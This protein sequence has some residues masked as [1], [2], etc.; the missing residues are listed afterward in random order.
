MRIRS[1]AGARERIL[2]AAYDLFSR[3]GDRRGRD[4]HDPG[5][6]RHRQDE[7]IPPLRLE[8]PS[9]CVAFLAQREQRVDPRLARGEIKARA[10]EP[11]QR[12]LAIFDVFDGWFQ[13]P[14]FEGC[15]FINVLLESPDAG[16]VRMPAA[17][18]L[19]SIRTI[20]AGLAAEAGLAD[21][22]RFA[23]T[24]HFLMK[25]SIV[26]ARRRACDD[27]GAG[28]TAGG[29]DHHRALATAMS[30]AVGKDQIGGAQLVQ[31]GLLSPRSHA[32]WLRSRDRFEPA[33]GR[34]GSASSLAGTGASAT[35][36]VLSAFRSPGRHLHRRLQRH[37]C[38]LNMAGSPTRRATTDCVTDWTMEP[39]ACPCHLKRER[40]ADP[41]WHSVSGDRPRGQAGWQA[42]ADHEYRAARGR[43]HIGLQVLVA[44][45]T[46]LPELE[47]RL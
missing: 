47:I 41:V 25:G 3:Q 2:A 18:H 39:R 23:R 26:T 36:S 37:L 29:R 46:S 44:G 30:A 19:A 16:G 38:K 6:L 34:V 9:W 21:P 40:P 5:P 22:E 32:G 11:E 1:A 24:W 7:P 20:L 13:E 45:G 42:R 43:G 28:G 12:L 15:S 31:A 35:V 17:A 14:G 10:M 27:C 33:L 4:R 8:G